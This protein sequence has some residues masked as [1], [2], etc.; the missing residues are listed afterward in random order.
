MTMNTT[1]MTVMNVMLFPRDYPT[2]KRAGKKQ[3][4]NLWEEMV[5]QVCVVCVMG[6]L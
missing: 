3:Q 6:I 2:N 5:S 4:R 1:V